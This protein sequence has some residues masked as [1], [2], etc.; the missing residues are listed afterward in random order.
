MRVAAAYCLVVY[1]M[2][3]WGSFP[4]GATDALPKPRL[5]ILP[6]GDPDAQMPLIQDL[7]FASLTRR[8]DFVLVERNSLDAILKEHALALAAGADMR[9][10]DLLQCGKLLS[11]EGLLL[12]GIERKTGTDQILRV[13]LL[14]ARLGLKVLD[15]LIPVGAQPSD[16][17]RTAEAVADCVGLRAP[18]IGAPLTDLRV[19]GVSTFRSE[20]HSVRWD[21]L[22][23]A[24]PS[25]IERALAL[26]G[27]VVLAERREVTPL[28]SER[29]VAPSLPESLL[30]AAWHADG[31]FRVDTSR[32]RIAV[33]VSARRGA[34]KPLDY[35]AEVPLDELDFLCREIAQRLAA[36]SGDAAVRIVSDPRAEAQRSADEARIY[37]RRHEALRAYPAA[38]SAYV[39][40]PNDYEYQRLFLTVLVKAKFHAN[41][42]TRA[43]P[44]DFQSS[45]FRAMDLAERIIR[46]YGESRLPAQTNAYDSVRPVTCCL[47]DAR[48]LLHARSFFN[49]PSTYAEAT[50]RYWDLCQLLLKTFAEKDET[51]L[52]QALFYSVE[53]LCFEENVDVSLRH[54]DGL[55]KDYRA[56]GAIDDLVAK[57]NTCWSTNSRAL[58]KAGDSFLSLLNAEDESV[59]LAA[60]KAGLASGNPDMCLKCAKAFVALCRKR[61]TLWLEPLCRKTYSAD[62]AESDR[63][64]ANYLSEMLTFYLESPS[65]NLER[66]Q[67]GLTYD[68]VE[69]TVRLADLLA[70]AGRKQ[71]AVEWLN[72]VKRLDKFHDFPNPPRCAESQ[73]LSKLNACMQKLG[74][75]LPTNEQPQPPVA[76][77]RTQA[78]IVFQYDSAFTRSLSLSGGGFSQLVM[79]ESGPA[80]VFL[81][82]LNDYG[83]I[84]LNPTDLRFSS[85]NKM[86][87]QPASSG[88]PLYGGYYSCVKAL[89]STA[90]HSDVFV[91]LPSRGLLVFRG[92]GQVRHVDENSGL[93]Y[94]GIWR[95]ECAGGHIYAFVSDT[96]GQNRGIMEVDLDTYSSRLLTSTRAEGQT[97]ALAGFSVK[98]L[99]ADAAH[100]TLWILAVE[101]KESWNSAQRIVRYDPKTKAFEQ[102]SQAPLDTFLAR[103]RIASLVC[104]RCG[105]GDSLLFNMGGWV[106]G[107]DLKA[108]QGM[109][110]FS[111]FKNGRDRATCFVC[112]DYFVWCATPSATCE[113]IDVFRR[114]EQTPVAL[115]KAALGE[116]YNNLN[117]VLDMMESDKGLYVLTRDTLFLFPNIR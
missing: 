54:I 64:E 38:E 59:R 42:A 28:L 35:Q 86:T 74:V 22:S 50:E 6:T 77:G 84:R 73:H 89:S 116:N 63:I 5:A 88:G 98:G 52:N 26:H 72:R 94:N 37:M 55:V 11:A 87:V 53:G 85:A 49:P 79:T 82:N 83:V 92:D 69:G 32:R 29:E 96:A 105:S 1:L 93:A 24:I 75:A 34:D 108:Q 99:C 76:G 16:L 101:S 60:N 103:A 10:D 15:T 30:A 117:G 91:G 40:M 17:A 48:D 8:T 51:L 66:R 104:C 2:F 71:D 112:G 14:D 9:P 81:S 4:I 57:I 109:G 33:S 47:S 27:N 56:L 21:W 46:N 65:L 113:V 62:R 36:A 58:Q 107:Y 100:E 78:R 13:R 7:L 12:L 18:R 25:G 97:D 102:I 95:L 45:Y 90:H 44:V 111:V 3:G 19:I 115:L 23:D 39:L 31:T 110:L 20:A 67:A 80:I 43:L 114:N 106:Y 41:P 70:Q 61:Q 68:L